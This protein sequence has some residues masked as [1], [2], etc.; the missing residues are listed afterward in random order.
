NKGG[1]PQK[2]SADIIKNITSAM[3]SGAYVE[4]AAVYAGINKL[5]FYRWLKKGNRSKSGLEWE[6]C[7]AV[8]QALAE[9]E[10]RD[11]LNIERA[12]M[13]SDAQFVNGRATREAVS[14]DW[15]ASAWRLER[16]FPRKWGRQE[17]IEHVGPEGGPIQIADV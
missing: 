9:S 7:N 6:L 11:L 3:K 13:G 8:E 16:K 12:A 1:A 15:K 5:T 2:L 10:L 17:R 14:P 4:T